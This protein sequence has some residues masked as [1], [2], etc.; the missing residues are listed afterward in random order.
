MTSRSSINTVTIKQ[1]AY[2]AI[3]HE[4]QALEI[5]SSSLQDKEVKKLEDIGYTLETATRNRKYMDMVQLLNSMVK[6]L[7]EKYLQYINVINK[8]QTIINNELEMFDME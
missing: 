4:L 3:Q 8:Y 7:E 2:E 6:E 5:A 1:D